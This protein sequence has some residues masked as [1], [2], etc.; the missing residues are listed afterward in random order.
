MGYR[1]VS[2][3]T[4]TPSCIRQKKWQPTE[5]LSRWVLGIM[6]PAF[7]CMSDENYYSRWIRRFLFV[8]VRNR[9][10][11]WVSWG[12]PVLPFLTVIGTSSKRVNS[13][14]TH[15]LCASVWSSWSEACCRVCRGRTFCILLSRHM[16]RTPSAGHLANHPSCNKHTFPSSPFFKYTHHRQS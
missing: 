1:R 10:R 6:H 13:L 11:P 2:L 12:A 15:H 9:M 7:T 14:W 5:N 8:T 16:G 3:C 4:K